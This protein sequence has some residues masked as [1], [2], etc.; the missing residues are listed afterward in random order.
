M[1]G[2]TRR[3]RIRNENICEIVGIARNED[4][5]KENRLRCFSHTQ[6]RPIEATHKKG[7][8][9]IVDVNHRGK[10]RPKLTSDV[11]VKKDMNLLDL[12]NHIV[13][14]RSKWKKGI[15]IADPN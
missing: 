10:G 14:D 9:I 6:Q 7:D 8:K 3:E 13:I 15:R 12:T 5:L 1:S 4:K 2:K 11:V